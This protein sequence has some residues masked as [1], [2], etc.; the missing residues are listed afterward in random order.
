MPNIPTP[1]EKNCRACNAVLPIDA[2]GIERHSRDGRN[3]EC[4]ECRR[5]AARDWTI[6]NPTA[7]ALRSAREV[8]KKDGKSHPTLDE[9]KAKRAVL[10]E[11]KANPRTRAADMNPEE[12][13][14]GLPAGLLS[15]QTLALRC[16]IGLITLHKHRKQNTC[17]IEDARVQLRRKGQPTRVVFDSAKACAFIEFMNGN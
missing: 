13:Q 4:K 2:F 7:A 9:V 12:D 3:D 10:D 15:R 16:G 1:L 8:I 17:G 11:A 6:R 5:Q 14:A